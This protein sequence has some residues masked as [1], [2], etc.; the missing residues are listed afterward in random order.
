VLSCHR[1]ALQNNRAL[2]EAKIAGAQS[3]KRGMWSLGS[4]RIS[5]ADHKRGVTAKNVPALAAARGGAQE[6]EAGRSGKS[7]AK[8]QGRGSSVLESAM[9]GLELVG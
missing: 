4:Q 1:V 2:L 9:T 6:A 8:N 7:K 5:A 3:K